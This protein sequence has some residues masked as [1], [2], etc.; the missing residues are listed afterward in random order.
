MVL[1]SVDKSKKWILIWSCSKTILKV[2]MLMKIPIQFQAVRRMRMTH[3]DS[4]P[5]SL[6]LTWSQI[7]ISSHQYRSYKKM[8]PRLRLNKKIQVSRVAP[9]VPLL[10]P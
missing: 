3:L 1:R 6:W 9:Q 4:V 5:M 2:S 8:S 7:K 10:D